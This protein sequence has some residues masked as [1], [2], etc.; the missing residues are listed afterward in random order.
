MT[1]KLCILA[2]LFC[3][4]LTGC[5]NAMKANTAEDAKVT[6]KTKKVLVKEIEEIKEDKVDEAIIEQ[7]PE[8]FDK[9]GNIVYPCTKYQQ[10]KWKKADK[11]G[12]L[13]EILNLPEELID[14]LSTK[15]LLKVV[16]NYPLLMFYIYYD[17]EEA[18]YYRAR[19]FNG[20]EELLKREDCGRAAFESYCGRDIK[21]AEKYNDLKNYMKDSD[22]LNQLSLEEYLIGQESTYEVLAEA[23]RWH[24]IKT[25]KENRKKKEK[26][27]AYSD[28]WDDFYGFEAIVGKGENPWNKI[29]RMKIG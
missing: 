17:M 5:G 12:K 6:D 24:M 20:M 14:A 27:A 9:D 8:W 16:E 4:L 18:V 10:K 1:K 19:M 11:E 13:P 29:V 21:P 25:Y 28:S 3:F 15:Q 22:L 2:I 26:L 7:Y 23:E